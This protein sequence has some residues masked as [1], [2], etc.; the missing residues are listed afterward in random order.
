MLYGY[1]HF[2]HYLYGR[3]ASVITDHCSPETIVVNPI[4]KAPPRIKKLML[5]LQPYDLQLQ[6]RLVSAI[7]VADPFSRLHLPDTDDKLQK[8]LY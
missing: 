1:K 5:Q 3:R 8:V 7:P 4:D 2:H 6:F